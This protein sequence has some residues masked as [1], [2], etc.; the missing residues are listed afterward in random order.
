MDA[1]YHGTMTVRS[2]W[3]AS[4]LALA[5]L[6]APVAAPARAQTSETEAA[7]TLALVQDGTEFVRRGAVLYD[8]N[9]SA[10]HGDT[11]RGLAEAKA[12]FPAAEQNCTRCH[13]TTNPPQMD[14]LAMN[15][16]NAFEIGSAPALLG[17]GATLAPY[18][19]GEGLYGYLRATMP[20]P[21][22]GSLTDEEYAM[23]TGFLVAADGVVE[24]SQ[25]GG[26]EDLAGIDLRR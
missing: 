1:R 17:Q 15:W 12:S 19:T 20:R 24:A 8:H 22:P 23:I 13:K 2:S 3:V 10:C 18:A 5:W 4:F 6:A 7:A 16:R 14:H 21:F 26:P 11:G 25:I 9:C